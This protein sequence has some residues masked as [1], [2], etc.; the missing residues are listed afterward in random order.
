MV[1]ATVQKTVLVMARE[2]DRTMVAMKE[3]RKVL[4]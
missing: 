2:K 1:V 3:T 4:E